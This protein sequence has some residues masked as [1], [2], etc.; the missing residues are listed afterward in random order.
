MAESHADDEDGT[1]I[2]STR[3]SVLKGGSTVLL[4]AI[5]ASALGTGAANA[6]E[7]DGAT[8][9]R[10]TLSK[11]EDGDTVRLEPDGEYTIS[12]DVTVGANN[13]TLEGNGATITGSGSFVTV[14][15]T[16]DSYDI[17][18]FAVDGPVGWT[19]RWMLE[20][21]DWDFHNVAYKHEFGG[22]AQHLLLPTNELEETTAT[23][24]DV[25]FGAGLANGTQESAIKAHFNPGTV[26]DLL[27]QRVYFFQNGTYLTNTGSS[28]ETRLQGAVHFRDCYFQSCYNANI[29][30]G[31][32]DGPPCT[33]DNCVIVVNED[34][35]PS[36]NSRGIWAFWNTIE[37]T[38]THVTT[39]ND[40]ALNTSAGKTG[41]IE[42]SGGQING[43]ID[44]ENISVTNTGNDPKQTPPEAC[45]ETPEA[46]IENN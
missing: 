43:E 20:G 2:R 10:E 31:S 21:G 19:V 30:T 28:G 38:N 45:P 17:G 41:A 12:G 25:W 27:V 46:A 5:G 26:G 35:K 33:V 7:P 8:D 6:L 34:E 15:A 24:S 39:P 36:H 37:I 16:G 32:H 42:F 9:L 11:V 3:R 23:I 44:G 29:R 14:T 22:G 1:K 13:W 40:T 4:G 18:G